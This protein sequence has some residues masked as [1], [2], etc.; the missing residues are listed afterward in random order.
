[1]L[2]PR[3]RARGTL[4][5]NGVQRSRSL[6]EDITPFS[7][8]SISAR[9]RANINGAS[10]TGDG[11]SGP[12]ISARR[13]DLRER[14]REREREGGPWRKDTDGETCRQKRAASLAFRVA[15][16][17]RA[18][19]SQEFRSGF[20]GNPAT[21]GMKIGERSCRD[22]TSDFLKCPF[23]ALRF[24]RTLRFGDADRR[25]VRAKSGQPLPAAVLSLPVADSFRR[26][27]R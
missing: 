27:F 2:E 23:S 11:K 25:T 13:R 5:S 6:R 10:R 24:D 21:R 14:R 12:S 26:G 18:S 19:R 7:S 22:R 1:M 4:N 15:V 17:P 8:F 3:C 16:F 20:A 9:V